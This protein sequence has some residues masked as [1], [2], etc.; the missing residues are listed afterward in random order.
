MKMFIF[1]KR[2]FFLNEVFFNEGFFK[3]FLWRC[4][5]LGRDFLF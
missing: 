4:F 5:F 2:L 3:G 1:R